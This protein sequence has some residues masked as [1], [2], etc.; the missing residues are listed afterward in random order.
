MNL[1]R[2]LLIFLSAWILIGSF[3]GCGTGGAQPFEGLR[4]T[5]SMRLEYATQFSVDYYEGG[6]KMIALADGSRFFVVPEGKKL[7]DGAS[8]E[9]TPV[10]QPLRNIYLAATSAMCLFDALGRLDAITLSGTKA[11]GWYIPHAKEAME[12]GRIFYAGKYSSPDYELITAHDCPM[13]IESMMI[14]H[15]SD[16]KEQLEELGIAV[17]M[18]QSSN[19][20]HPLGRTEWIK[21][22]GA[23]LNEEEKAEEIFSEQKSHLDGVSELS[24]SGKTVAFFHVSSTGRIIARKSGDYVSKMIALAGGRYVFEDL[25]DSTT[26]TSTV[27][28][29]PEYFYAE[30]K[31]ADVIIYNAAIAEEIGSIGEMVDK[32]G[33]LADFKAVKTGDVWCTGK[34]MYQDT[35]ALGE[36]IRSIYE[37]LSE[38]AGE[39]DELPFFYR[40]K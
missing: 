8:R 33:L 26:K 16:I 24:P 25:G 29:D 2:A 21:V 3:A 34:N 40:L 39:K 22:Y 31:D 35:T 23:L 1:K 7:P 32:C 11:E 30:A 15:A 6:Y 9:A 20:Q 10:Y 28:L 18:D 12:E 5:G 36:M 19:E 4:L 13:A 37:I 14:G 38:D 17:F 27:T